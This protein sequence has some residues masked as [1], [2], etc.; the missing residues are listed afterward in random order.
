MQPISGTDTR[1][2]RVGWSAKN[3]GQSLWT[4]G[5][6][7]RRRRPTDSPTRACTRRDLTTGGGHGRAVAACSDA[8]SIGS[9]M[10]IPLTRA[11]TQ[12]ARVGYE[13]GSARG[14]FGSSPAPVS[15]RC[16]AS[17]PHRLRPSTQ[18]LSLQTTARP[19]A[20]AK[21][22]SRSWTQGLPAGGPYRAIVREQ[23]VHHYPH[24]LFLWSTH[25]LLALDRGV[26]ALVRSAQYSAAAG[27]QH[28]RATQRWGTAPPRQGARPRP[29]PRWRTSTRGGGSN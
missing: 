15:E 14:P 22:S 13:D 17:H 8:F 3:R 19:P 26:A 12:A 28:V 2:Q 18:W 20:T 21:V 16:K 7:H 24:L 6:P 4:R 10:V 9:Y 5:G 11:R 1:S 23:R 27:H 25:L 29:S